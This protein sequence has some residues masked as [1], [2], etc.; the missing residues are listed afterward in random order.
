MVSRTPQ[1]GHSGELSLPV[2]VLNLAETIRLG[3]IGAVLFE[4][5]LFRQRARKKEE[6]PNYD[7]SDVRVLPG[8]SHWKFIICR[9]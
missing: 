5:V 1:V 2:S 9:V 7:P 3:P 6:K 8:K 4:T